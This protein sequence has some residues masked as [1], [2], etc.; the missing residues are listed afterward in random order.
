MKFGTYCIFLVCLQLDLLSAV[1][2]F[3]KIVLGCSL[4]LFNWTF[5]TVSIQWKDRTVFRKLLYVRCRVGCCKGIQS[6]EHLR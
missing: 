2:K 1:P 6:V 4:M 3:Q 5:C